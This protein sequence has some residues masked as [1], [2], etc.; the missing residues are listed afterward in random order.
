MTAQEEADSVL[1]LEPT[2]VDQRTAF[3]LA[4][5]KAQQR[6]LRPNWC[7]NRFGEG[8]GCDD[9]ELDALGRC[10]HLIGYALPPDPA[11]NRKAGEKFFALVSVKVASGR[12]ADGTITL[13]ESR[14][15]PKQVD[16]ST[17]LPVLPDDKLV[18]VTKE[19]VARVYRDVDALPELKSNKKTANA[20]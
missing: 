19:N 10:R 6:G 2:Q 7:K 20:G 8:T 11:K 5:A 3:Q 15:Y 9:S 18:W 17:E 16:G 14:V 12:A 4:D 1:S 13:K